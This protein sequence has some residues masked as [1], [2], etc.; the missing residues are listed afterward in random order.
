MNKVYYPEDFFDFRDGVKVPA[1]QVQKWINECISSI[2]N[3][4]NGTYTCISSGNTKVIVLK[5][6]DGCY[7]GKNGKYDI[8]VSTGHLEYMG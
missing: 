1:C 8:I 5:A 3:D 7:E 6:E 2:D 4:L